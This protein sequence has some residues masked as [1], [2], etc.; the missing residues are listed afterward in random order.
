MR[1]GVPADE[2]NAGRAGFNRPGL[3][4]QFGVPTGNHQQ[5]TH[6]DEIIRTDARV[7]ATFRSSLENPILDR[8]GSQISSACGSRRRA[9]E[10]NRLPVAPAGPI[11]GIKP[12]FDKSPGSDKAISTSCS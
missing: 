9:V 5:Q 7:V 10:A 3:R 6:P 12:L 1:T 4:Y 8:R 11:V 2:A